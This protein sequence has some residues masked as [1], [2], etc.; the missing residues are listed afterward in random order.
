[1]YS[2]TTIKCIYAIY[3]RTA[4]FCTSGQVV[5]IVAVRV[6]HSAQLSTYRKMSKISSSPLN[7]VSILTSSREKDITSP[8][9]CLASLYWAK[10]T[11]RS[12]ES[13]REVHI[14]RL[15]HLKHILYTYTP[16]QKL[17]MYMLSC[18][19]QTLTVLY[20]ELH[21][22]MKW[23]HSYA[24]TSSSLEYK[25]KVLIMSMLLSYM[26]LIWMPWPKDWRHSD[27]PPHVC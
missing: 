19:H 6:F 26:Q 16:L 3:V 25:E 8:V 5:A 12:L 13:Q 17:C 18:I 7:S 1:M 14:P 10:M 24:S 11:W 20:I 9:T 21:L 2:I 23:W 4:T 27:I 22:E 15:I